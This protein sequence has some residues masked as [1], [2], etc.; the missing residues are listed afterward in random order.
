[1]NDANE[2][3][4]LIAAMASGES[5]DWDAARERA[6]TADDRARVE[7]LR[8]IEQIA[9]FSHA[10]WERFS[11][12]LEGVL[13]EQATALERVANAPGAA[14]GSGHT[15]G[16]Y[17]LESPIGEGGMGTVW[18]ARRSDGRFEAR[19]AVKLL[20]QPRVGPEGLARFKREGEI[21]ARLRHPNIAQL[22]DA[23]VANG[24]Q[25]YLVLEYVDGVAI[26]RYCDAHGLDTRGRIVLFLDVLAAVAH[27]QTN[28]VL[29]RDLKPSNVLVDRAGHV[30]LLDFG[31]AK[32]LDGDGLAGAETELTQRAGHAF[33]PEF[34]APEQLRG[35]PV[36]TSTDV[37]SA[38]VL[39]YLLLT[40]RH[41]TEGVRGSPA[42]RI[43]AILDT[44]PK[45][46]SDA[47]PMAGDEQARVGPS[48]ARL[49][50]E[51]QGDLDNILAKALKKAPEERYASAAAFADDLR[52]Y[53]N[54]EPVTARA[55]TITYRIG[56]FVR[57]HRAAV[58][59][60]AAV[61]LA[62]LGLT[63]VAISQLFEARRQ[64]DAARAQQRLAEGFNNVATSLLSQVGPGGRALTPEEL[65]DRA[66]T[67]T[68]ARYADD[69]PFLVDMLIRI[70]G[71]YMDLSKH[72]KELATLVQA[73]DLAR[74]AGDAA[75]LFRVQTNTVET[76]LVLGRKVEARRRIEEARALLP[77]LR[78]APSV[79]DYLRAEAEVAQADGKVLEAIDYLEKGRRALEESGNTH[80][81]SYAGLLSV[82]RLHYA[83]A[84]NVREAHEYAL[85]MVDNV[86][87]HQ[88]EQTVGGTS[89][90][91]T[92]AVSVYSLGEVE[93]S[94]GLFEEAIPE[95]QDWTPGKPTS[96]L[97]LAWLYGE[98]LSR[99]GRHE[100][101]IPMIRESLGAVVEGGN[102]PRVIRARLGFAR[103]L[104]RAGQLD[105]ITPMLAEV[106][107]AIASD[108]AAYRVWRPEAIRIQAEVD[109]AQG[110]LDAAESG[111]RRGL[112]SVG[113]PE[114]QQAMALPQ[115]LLTLARVQRAKQQSAQ[116]LESAQTAI[117]FF[118][119]NAL[120][121]KQSADVGEALLELA[122]IQKEAHD[123]GAAER[124]LARAIASLRSGL[125]AEHELV[126]QAERLALTL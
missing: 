73:E 13:G 95:L 84:G 78:P 93:K 3:E 59:T 68:S 92:F 28:L 22:L 14:P 10:Q 88:R 42:E 41:P 79:H 46:A 86:R 96:W 109:L 57:R 56:K 77:S 63:F 38:A 54:Q 26:D 103:A 87:A 124:T 6:T 64:R 120:D 106:E 117:G 72:E 81:N 126:R 35:E 97:T 80:G 75:L 62:L 98:I 19:A 111:A 100:A 45:L 9:A 48:P 24:G 27:A 23:G 17:T 8:G 83:V 107:A 125:G 25:P 29:H 36:T 34:A 44:T 116:A 32:L 1:M 90:R 112:Q 82:L 50:R 74:R 70:S 66:V 55:D 18:L 43:A 51:L 53:L 60:S 33:T 114:T 61:V 7:A 12:V 58:V 30:K 94:R 2:F 115:T 123:A 110:R 21:L 104:L 89:A 101:A 113:Y 49:R 11:P 20:Q 108:E 119:R 4:R 118:E 65:L 121:P 15:V 122:Q 67:E 105:E 91:A 47:I 5:V 85:R 31:I 69:V 39:L 16:T 99:L 40:G 102:K 52:R 37:Y 71:R 76:E